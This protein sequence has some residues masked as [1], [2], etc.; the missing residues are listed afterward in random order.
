M[1]EVFI[2]TSG[3]G[4]FFVSSEP[5]HADAVAYVR[6]WRSDGTR[7][8]TTNYVLAELTA[9]F[10]RPL[11]LPRP[12][13]LRVADTLRSESWVEI[14]HIDPSLDAQAWALLKQRPDKEWSLA[15]AASFLVM[16]QRG[17]TE[18]L[19]GDHHFDQAGFI[20]LLK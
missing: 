20:R 7:L 5:F 8:I 11:R 2:D 18:A 4:S 12:F 9:L 13:L 15:D 14:V 19:T 10:T 6:R 3:W 17:I 16:R 1:N